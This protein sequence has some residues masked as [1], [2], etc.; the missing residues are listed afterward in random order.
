[1][2][3]N[4]IS[5]VIPSYNKW[6]LLH[7]LLFDI[8][9]FNRDVF[10]VLVI[11]NG[12]TDLEY[13]QGLEWWRNSKMLPIHVLELEENI[14]FLRACNAGVRASKGN[15]VI[16]VSNDV[17]ITENITN[18]ITETLTKSKSIIGGKYYLQSTGWND[19]GDK[20]FPY[21]EGWLL[22]FTR[23]AWNELGGFDEIFAPNDY[24]DIDFSTKALAMGYSLV[25]LGSPKVSHLGAKTILYG[26][27]REAI[28]KQ[29]RKKF[30]KKWIK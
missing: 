16:L 23:E 28:T 20:M 15:M 13:F 7:Q 8:Y 25:E 1:M 10:E 17:R 4:K 14:G 11:N 6:G 30:Q 12:S 26:P 21:L 27:E 19:F 22:A 9:Q 29:N 18:K 2:A 24:E 3:S 5:F